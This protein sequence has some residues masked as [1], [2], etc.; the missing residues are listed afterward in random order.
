M[1]AKKSASKG[2]PGDGPVL[3]MILGDQLD[4]SYPDHLRLEKDRDVIL[5]AEVKGSSESPPS[6]IQRTVTFLS[7]MRHHAVKLR[8]KGWEVDY[9]TLTDRGNTHT[10]GGE[11]A[12]AI[13]RHAPAAAASV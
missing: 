1:P 4:L 7:A 2:D 6:H 10:L 9:I 3:C 11:L 13:S 12:R 8:E 5:M